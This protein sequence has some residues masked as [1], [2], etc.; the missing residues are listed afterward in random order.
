[1]GQCGQANPTN[2]YEGVCENDRSTYAPGPA[3]YRG[4]CNCLTMG[5]S[6]GYLAAW[7]YENGQLAG[8]GSASD[9][10]IDAITGMIYH[11][12][13]TNDNNVRRYALEAILA[14]IF[15]D[16]GYG[17]PFDT[18]TVG[19]KNYY[20]LKP[21]SCFGGFSNSYFE[22]YCYNPSY[23]APAQMRLF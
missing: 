1:G 9:G 7:K 20:V 23:F 15:T 21:G 11:A 8:T 18:R 5:T 12:E 22:P 4:C 13:A 3:N 10:D 14:F 16:I 17:S 2:G 6:K 19:G